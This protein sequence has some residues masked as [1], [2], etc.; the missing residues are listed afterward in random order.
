MQRLS[1]GRARGSSP[2]DFRR[3]CESLSDPS[4]APT[5]KSNPPAIT[6]PEERERANA[7][8][9]QKRTTRPR[10]GSDDC[11]Y[12]NDELHHDFSDQKKMGG[13]IAKSFLAERSHS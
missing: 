7:G 12:I 11:Y 9:L 10:L 8:S 2:I 5:I 3:T 13:A 4:I 6:E 1:E